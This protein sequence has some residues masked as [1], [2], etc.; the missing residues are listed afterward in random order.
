MFT[1]KLLNNFRE[2]FIAFA[3][4]LKRLFP[5]PVKL[6]PPRLRNDPRQRYQWQPHIKRRRREHLMCW[7]GGRHYPAPRPQR[8]TPKGKKP[9]TPIL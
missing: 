7:P 8:K 5:T 3:N 2:G 1:N 9:K 6:R 4:L